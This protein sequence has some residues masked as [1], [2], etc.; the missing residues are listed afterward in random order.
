LTLPHRYTGASLKFWFE[1]F[2]ALGVKHGLHWGF[3]SFEGLPEEANGVALECNA[4]LPG[5]F[6]A[7]DQFGAYTFGEV[8]HKIF[9]YL[10]PKHAAQTR[11]IKGF[12]SDSLTSTL[13]EDKGM[14]P[15]LLVDVDVDLYISAVQCLDWMLS[16]GLIVV[17]TVIYY[18][19]VSVIKADKGGELRAH[20]EMTDKY[21]IKWRKLHDSCWEVTAIG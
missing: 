21:N 1:Q 15:A 6:S 14:R 2:E 9:E 8:R 13:K 20:D 4:W 7:A 16:E 18:D 3:D 19:D 17:G 11:L 10:G 12:F 5:S